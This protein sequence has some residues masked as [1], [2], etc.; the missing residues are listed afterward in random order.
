MPNHGIHK[1]NEYITYINH[2][3]QIYRTIVLKQ[4]YEGK[5]LQIFEESI[6]KGSAFLFMP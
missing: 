5:L 1:L 6:L 2:S 4:N 3:T